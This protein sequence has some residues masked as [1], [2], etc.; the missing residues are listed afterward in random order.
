VLGFPSS[1]G[2]EISNANMI[3]Y[4]P[5]QEF[6]P[7]FHPPSKDVTDEA[8]DEFDEHVVGL[9]EG[10]TAGVLRRQG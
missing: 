3:A 8:D 7:P 5:P 2:I 9:S 6:R 10:E 4:P 1:K